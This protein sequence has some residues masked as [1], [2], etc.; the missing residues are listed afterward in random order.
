MKKR[1]RLIIHSCVPREAALLRFILPFIGQAMEA[2]T[3][4]IWAP[5][6]GPRLRFMPGTYFMNINNDSF[7]NI[8]RLLN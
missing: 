8:I 2:V 1:L 4:Y 6:T 5:L 3:Y 7:I